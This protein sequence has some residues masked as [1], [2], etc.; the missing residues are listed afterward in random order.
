LPAAERG[1]ALLLARKRSGWVGGLRPAL[2]GLLG[3]GKGSE[4]PAA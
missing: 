4:G 1:K 2:A 3:H